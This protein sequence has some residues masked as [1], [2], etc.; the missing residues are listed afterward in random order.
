MLTR[1]QRPAPA[2]HAFGVFPAQ[3]F[4]RCGPAPVESVYNSNKTDRRNRG[5]LARMVP[6]QSSQPQSLGQ[7]FSEEDCNATVTNS[8][9]R[10]GFHSGKALIPAAPI[11]SFNV[12]TRSIIEIRGGAFGCDV[13]ADRLGLS[14]SGASAFP[15]LVMREAHHAT[16]VTAH[17]SNR[18]RRSH[19]DR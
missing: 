3:V 15:S 16:E 2:R 12:P 4:V 10:C 19:P 17:S 6:P 8:H 7:T 14:W 11:S 9:G 18:L 5:N 13:L 1:R